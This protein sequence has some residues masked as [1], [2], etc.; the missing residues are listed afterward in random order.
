MRACDISRRVKDITECSGASH[1]LKKQDNVYCLGSDAAAGR[2]CSS[3]GGGAGCKARPLVVGCVPNP[4][5][6]T[7]PA[8]RDS[9]GKIVFLLTA[10]FSLNSYVSVWCV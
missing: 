2:L 7:A 10:S 1:M 5:T 9:N 8:G 6:S 3:P 4:W